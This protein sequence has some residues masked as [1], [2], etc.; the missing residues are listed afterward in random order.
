M[1]QGNNVVTPIFTP[2]QHFNKN[3][4]SLN[5]MLDKLNSNFDLN[6][7]EMEIVI[8]ESL[9]KKDVCLKVQ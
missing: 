7:E 2:N 3:T 1:I 6:H 9:T 8:K 5:Q 4:L